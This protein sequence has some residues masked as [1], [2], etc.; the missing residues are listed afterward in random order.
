MS[1]NL[2]GKCEKLL[3][4]CMATKR[5][6][7]TIALGEDWDFLLTIVLLAVLP[8]LCKG[9]ACVKWAAACRYSQD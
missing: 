6:L 2:E 1:G 7:W 5:L 3:W 9:M 4:L 8:G